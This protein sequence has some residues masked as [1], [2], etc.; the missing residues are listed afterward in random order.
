MNNFAVQRI[1]NPNVAGGNAISARFISYHYFMELP[2]LQK[3]IGTGFGNT[4]DCF[5]NSIAYILYGCG[6]LGLLMF[7]Y[8]NY[9]IL[10]K[11]I[12]HYQKIIALVYFG[13]YLMGATFTAILFSFTLVLVLSRTEDSTGQSKLQ[14]NSKKIIS[15]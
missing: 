2:T 1:I 11:S 4:R 8:M 12:L 3:I 9:Y 6:I 15:E 14:E 7:I 13:L 10:R 5:Y